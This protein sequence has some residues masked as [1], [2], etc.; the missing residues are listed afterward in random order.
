MKK[1]IIPVQIDS[2]TI[3]EKIYFIRGQ[4]VMLDK[5]LAEIY[6]YEVRRF[7]EQVNR[8]ID[9]FD[10]DFMFK[11]TQ[12]EYEILKSQIATSSWGGS[13]KIPNAFT[14][15]G[16]YML[17]TVLKNEL[18]VKQSKA[19]IRLFKSLKDFV[20][21]NRDLIP[22]KNILQIESRTSKLETTVDEMRTD[23]NKVMSNFID[24]DSY[25]HFLILDGKK[26]E[27]DMAYSKIY[28]TAKKSIYYI[29]NYVGLKTLDLLSN[30]K[31]GV[32]IT[33]FTDNVYKKAP[34]KQFMVDDFKVQ[35]PTNAIN[36]KKTNGKYHDRYIVVDYATKNETIYHCGA[37][38][39]DAGNKITTISKIEDV[40]LYRQMINELL[41][42][43]DLKI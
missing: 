30:V 13:R 6:G 10:E 4:K 8:N 36:L 20:S 1:E 7:N 28:K 3:K 16:I 19:L 15:Q 5:D 22:S 29:D 32:A 37:S 18:A 21:E 33:I 38:S 42:N 41:S 23:L 25:K 24:E 11:L 39:K 27:A 12:E 26:L 17:M 40:K 43:P 2:N 31:N 14:E 35:N 34:I 9:R